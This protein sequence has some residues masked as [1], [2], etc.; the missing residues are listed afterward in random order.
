MRR[1][2]NVLS[3]G[4][5]MMAFECSGAMACGAPCPASIF[6][7]FADL[8]AGVKADAI[9]QVEIAATSDSVTHWAGVD[10][11]TWIGLARVIKVLKGDIDSE[12]IRLYV[13]AMTPGFQV[14]ASGIVAGTLQ[15]NVAG[16]L[17]LRVM[18]HSPYWRP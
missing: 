4:I 7:D 11:S 12:V 8:V 1:S 16:V 2:F 6:V 13:P 3:V 14:G 15:R 9:V 17:E 10:R 18:L 5:F